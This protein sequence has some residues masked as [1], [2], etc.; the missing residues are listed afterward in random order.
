MLIH[1]KRMRIGTHPVEKK[2]LILCCQTEKR[3]ANT[4]IAPK[5]WVCNK[6]FTPQNEIEQCDSPFCQCDSKLQTF[7]AKIIIRNFFF[8][9]L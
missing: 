4:K 7:N 1:F 2:Q 5:E 8:L 3:F 9:F 6:G